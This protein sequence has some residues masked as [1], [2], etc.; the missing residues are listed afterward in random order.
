MTTNP[1]IQP[2]PQSIADKLLEKHGKVEIIPGEVCSKDLNKCFDMSDNGSFRSVSASDGRISTSETSFRRS[3]P[4]YGTVREGI[5]IQVHRKSKY[6]LAPFGVLTTLLLTQGTKVGIG[7]AYDPQAP[8][9]DLL[10]LEC[11]ANEVAVLSNIRGGCE[12]QEARDHDLYPRLYY[13]TGTIVVPLQPFDD[14]D[15]FNNPGAC[16]RENYKKSDFGISYY[17][18]KNDAERVFV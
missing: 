10:N 7:N 15:C 9:R 3:T 14:Q 12:V 4:N 17:L 8:T 2:I 13:D 11:R 6:K 16:T 18:C 5:A 1:P